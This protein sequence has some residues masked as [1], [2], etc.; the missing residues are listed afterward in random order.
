M[1][2]VKI[3]CK[4][5]IEISH[6]HLEESRVNMDTGG[7]GGRAREET[8]TKKGS[9][10]RGSGQETGVAKM[11]ELYRSQRSWGK[12]QPSFWAGEFR[13]GSGTS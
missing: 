1:V 2:E 10:G 6:R 11:V 4:Y 8:P 7:R 5:E 3:Y 13:V 9:P 12:G